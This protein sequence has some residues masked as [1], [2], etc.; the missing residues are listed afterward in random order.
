[1]RLGPTLLASRK[2][3][4]GTERKQLDEDSHELVLVLLLRVGFGQFRQWCPPQG[5]ELIQTE[6][7]Y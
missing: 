3:L 2:V 5:G 4:F 6:L 1:M 7:S